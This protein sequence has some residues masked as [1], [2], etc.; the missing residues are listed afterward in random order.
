MVIINKLKLISPIPP[1]VN[2]YLGYRVVSKRMKGRVQH[3]PV[4]YVKPEAKKYIHKFQLY[5]KQQVLKQGWD[6][7]NT[8]DKHHYMDCVFYFPRKDMDEQNYFKV[9]SDALNGIAYIDDKNLLTR[10]HK[11]MYDKNNPRV[12]I[13]IKPVEYTGLFNNEDELNKFIGTC[14]SCKQYKR[15]KERCSVYQSAIS[16]EITENIQDKKCLKYKKG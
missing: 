13:E 16:G 14:L 10:T 11:V 1:S 7:E 12:L 15:Y 5:A 2:H 4:P 3:I 8:R 9:M 6:I